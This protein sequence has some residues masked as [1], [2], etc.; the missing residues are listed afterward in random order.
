[1]K[2]A[3]ITSMHDFANA[4]Q[5]PLLTSKPWLVGLGI[6]AVTRTRTRHIALSDTPERETGCELWPLGMSLQGIRYSGSDL[7]KRSPRS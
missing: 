7:Q 5:D 4:E 3:E 2:I 1:M 6:A